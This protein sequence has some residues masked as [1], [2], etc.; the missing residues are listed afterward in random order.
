M[1]SWNHVQKKL[2]IQ[3][4]SGNH[5]ALVGDL[6]VRGVWQPQGTTIFDI[7]VT[8]FDVPSSISKP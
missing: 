2:V 4:A 1:E 5:E 8:D 6:T 3:E 7:R